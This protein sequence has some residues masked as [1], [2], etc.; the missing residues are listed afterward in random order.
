MFIE[1]K[2]GERYEFDAYRYL[3]IED[4]L[5]TLTIIQGYKDYR[6]SFYARSIA[7]TDVGELFDAILEAAVKECKHL[8]VGYEW[9]AQ[10]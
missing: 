1:L 5:I 2:C 9:E 4:G 10:E 6:P 3:E 8:S 7:A